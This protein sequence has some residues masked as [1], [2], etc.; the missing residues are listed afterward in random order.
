MGG[1]D[2]PLLQ[3]GFQFSEHLDDT[4]VRRQAGDDAFDILAYV[5]GVSWHTGRDILDGKV[6]KEA[7][8]DYPCFEEDPDSVKVRHQPTG[9][10]VH[11]APGGFAWLLLSVAEVLFADELFERGTIAAFESIEELLGF[12]DDLTVSAASEHWRVR[13]LAFGNIDLG[14]ALVKARRSDGPK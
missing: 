10:V 13:K 11:L 2:L 9:G 8:E 7:G 14:L 1:G 4:L 6:G 5:W 12:G 3:L